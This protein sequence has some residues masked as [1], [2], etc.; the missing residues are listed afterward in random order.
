MNDDAQRGLEPQP[1]ARWRRHFE[2]NRGRAMPEDI[3]EGDVP[4]SAVPLLRRSLAVFRVGETGEG[5]IASEI[6]RA[7]LRSVDADYVRA[8]EL[9]IA[10]EGR[11]AAILGRAVR[12]LGGLPMGSHW[13]AAAFRRVRR[14]GGVRFELLTLLVAEIV[15][16]AFYSTLA[17]ALSEKSGLGA[18]LAEMSADERAHLAFHVDLFRAEISTL[19]SRA[20]FATLFV[21]LSGAAGVVAFADHGRALRAAGGSPL[22]AARRYAGLASASLRDVVVS[23]APC[24]GGA[25]SRSGASASRVA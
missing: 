25:L 7:G 6:A 5:R 15:G 20:A 2:Q 12:S 16:L 17:S 19:G 8:F 14:A 11:H 21:A 9:F 23:R 4:R 10:E 24:G 1:W 3:E 18:A 22:G 13:T